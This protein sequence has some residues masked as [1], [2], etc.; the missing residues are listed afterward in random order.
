MGS[1]SA[2]KNEELDRAA[3]QTA[4]T[5]TTIEQKTIPSFP[6]VEE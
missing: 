5:R 1:A 3:K 6:Y 2:P 4:K